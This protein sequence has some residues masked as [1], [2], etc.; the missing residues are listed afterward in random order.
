MSP[1]VQKMTVQR[2]NQTKLYFPVSPA[3]NFQSLACEMSEI[4][5]MIFR[6]YL[7][8]YIYSKENLLFLKRLLLFTIYYFY[9]L[10]FCMYYILY[11]LCFYL[12]TNIEIISCKEFR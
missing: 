3:R 8:F 2:Q 7:S 9:I 4:T 6:Y 12:N 5:W 1:R 10:Y 11:V